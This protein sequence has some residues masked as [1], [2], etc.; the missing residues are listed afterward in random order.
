[1]PTHQARAI[2][3][4]MP[5]GCRSNRALIVSTIEVTGSAAQHPVTPYDGTAA[6]IHVSRASQAASVIRTPA[7]FL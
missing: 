5:T 7:L 4:S 6:G 2:Q 3:M 1:M